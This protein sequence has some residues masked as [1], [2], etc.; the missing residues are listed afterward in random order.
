VVMKLLL[1]VA[2]ALLAIIVLLYAFLQFQVTPLPSKSN[3][4]LFGSK[5][6]KN[7]ESKPEN[8]THRFLCE[9]NKMIDVYDDAG[10]PRGILYSNE[11]T[12]DENKAI[13]I[14]NYFL[15]FLKNEKFGCKLLNI[16]FY[17]Q[18]K[19]NITYSW[20]LTKCAEPPWYAYF[21][22]YRCNN[23]NLSV[24]VSADSEC[25]IMGRVHASFIFFKDKFID[26]AR[27]VSDCNCYYFEPSAFNCRKFKLFE[28]RIDFMECNPPVRG[29]IYTFRVTPKMMAFVGGG[30]VYVQ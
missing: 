19:D 23:F 4:Y 11:A 20:N 26:F 10:V 7:V 9:G 14:A 3:W 30:G 13:E 24:T 29:I 27:T 6:C 18:Y 2:V 5:F 17:D 22:R 28:D 12:I 1:I 21:I 15:D 16:E 25:D 8:I